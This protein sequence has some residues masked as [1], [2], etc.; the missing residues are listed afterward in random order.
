MQKKKFVSIVLCFFFFSLS[1]EIQSSAY[2]KSIILAGAGTVSMVSGV[3]FWYIETYGFPEKLKLLAKA[4]KSKGVKKKKGK[5]IKKEKEVKL[6]DDFFGDFAL[7]DGKNRNKNNYNEKHRRFYG[8]LK[9]I[10][11]MFGATFF[12][13]ALS[14]VL[15]EKK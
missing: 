8:T 1:T 15:S 4:S 10:S 2:K 12:G 9:N 3:G 6:L 13:E 5:K 11:F 14:D 7:N